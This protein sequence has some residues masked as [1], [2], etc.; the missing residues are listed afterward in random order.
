MT[1]DL[2]IL[3]EGS[4]VPESNLLSLVEVG[5][6]NLLEARGASS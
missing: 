4:K 5:S 6:R 3:D 1:A 2:E